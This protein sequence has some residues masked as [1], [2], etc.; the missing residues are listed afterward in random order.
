MEDEVR[1]AAAEYFDRL[2]E[3][4]G[5]LTDQARHVYSLSHE[6]AR[7]HPTGMI[8]GAFGIGLIVGLLLDRD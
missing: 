8:A 1:R 3:A 6:Y 4:A 7:D 5:R 2:T